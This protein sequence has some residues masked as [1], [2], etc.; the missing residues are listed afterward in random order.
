MK[1]KMK[2]IVTLT[3]R[4][5]F[6]SID[7]VTYGWQLIWPIAWIYL[8]GYSITGLMGDEKISINGV[9]VPYYAFVAVGMIVFNAMN[10]SEVSGSIIWKDK[11]NGMLLQLL[12]MRYNIFHYIVSNLIT[13]VLMGL[14]SALVIGIIGYP[15]FGNYAHFEIISFVCFIYALITASIFF[16][17]MSIV[18]SCLTR[19]SEQFAMFSNGL[20][21]FFTFAAATFYPLYSVPEPLRTIFLFNPMTHFMNLTREGIFGVVEQPQVFIELS[22]ITVSTIVIFALAFHLMKKIKI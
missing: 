9:D 18:L 4:N 15:A 13:I 5:M 19:N 22:V 6:I 10:T 12:T 17:S 20:H 2:S 21:Y 1:N 7:K 14:A 8:V 16:G 3:Y 11:R